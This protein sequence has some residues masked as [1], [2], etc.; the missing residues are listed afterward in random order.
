VEDFLM[1]WWGE[2]LPENEP[3]ALLKVIL[4]VEVR[5]RRANL[6]DEG[7]RVGFEHLAWISQTRQVHRG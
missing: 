5:P 6:Y 1:G 4:P 7:E 2:C 3:L